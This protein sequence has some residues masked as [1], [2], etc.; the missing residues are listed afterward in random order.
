MTT[1]FKIANIVADGSNIIVFYTFSN[2]IDYNNRF[3]ATAPVTDLVEWGTVEAQK[4]DT[5]IAEAERRVTELQ[6][7]LL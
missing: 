5:A 7:E 3:P 6:Q 2:G 4:F 1:T